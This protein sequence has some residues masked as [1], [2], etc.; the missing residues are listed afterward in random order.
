MAM[1]DK[2]PHV[3]MIV[4]VEQ[5]SWNALTRAWD[6]TVL[7]G[8]G[9]KEVHMNPCTS[10]NEMNKAKLG[11]SLHVLLPVSETIALARTMRHL[12]M[13]SGNRDGGKLLA[14]AS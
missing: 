6:K 13:M 1:I 8:F 7:V 9:S 10:A 2:Q 11:T 4:R 14:K 5:Q 12:R 3:G